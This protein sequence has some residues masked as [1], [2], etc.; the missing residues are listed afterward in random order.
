MYIKSVISLMLSLFLVMGLGVTTA[1]AKSDKTTICH[2]NSS[3]GG[4][5]TVTIEVANASL[6]AHYA[7]GDTEGACAEETSSNDNESSS[8]DDESSSNDD[9]SSSNDDESSSNDDESSSNDDDSVTI[10]SSCSLPTGNVCV[11]DTACYP[12]VA[13]STHEEDRKSHSDNKKS[14]ED[15][16]KSD[17]DELKSAEDSKHSHEEQ[18]AEHEK[19]GASDAVLAEDHAAIARDDDDIDTAHNK[20]TQ[21]HDDLDNDD[22]DLKS[23]NDSIDEEK[24]VALTT[25]GAT[26]C[27]CIDGSMGYLFNNAAN[28]GANPPAGSALTPLTPNSAGSGNGAGSSFREISGQ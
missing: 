6:P 13:N 22:S 7:H 23:D 4:T 20:V 28:P 16:L 14:H 5:G 3:N 10:N 27:T 15:K 18:L 9:E 8:N 21:D 25:V 24:A 19:D 17:E 1:S 26:A 12:S 2:H 11:C